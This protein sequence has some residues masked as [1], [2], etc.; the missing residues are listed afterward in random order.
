MTMQ[1]LRK[2][3]NHI[4]LRGISIDK[5]D[6][7]HTDPR[8]PG[9]DISSK[10]LELAEVPILKTGVASIY[11]PQSQISL[12]QITFHKSQLHVTKQSAWKTT[13]RR[14]LVSNVRTPQNYYVSRCQNTSPQ[15]GQFQKM[16]QNVSNLTKHM[17]KT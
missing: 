5:L 7:S 10:H 9:A 16:P 11:A 3:N 15:E 6:F 13:R 12:I 14:F 17:K 4:M 2:I 8:T 1:F